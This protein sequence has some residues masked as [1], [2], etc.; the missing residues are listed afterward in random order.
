MSSSINGY[1][2]GGIKMTV[3]ENLV[4][5]VRL[6]WLKRIFSDNESAWKFYL[7]HL[8]R[9]VGGLLIFKCNCVISDLSINSVFYGELLES[10][11]E[12]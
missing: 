10:W 8:L 5:A 12:F 6:A 4:K 11:L 9:N 7:L 2:D 1:E 3:I